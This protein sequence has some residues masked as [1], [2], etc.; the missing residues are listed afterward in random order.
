MMVK[1]LGRLDGLQSYILRLEPRWDKSGYITKLIE[2]K[3]IGSH[4]YLLQRIPRFPNPKPQRCWKND[5]ETTT[6][7]RM[8]TRLRTNAMMKRR[9]SR[10]KARFQGGWTLRTC[11][12]P[13]FANRRSCAAKHCHARQL[14]MCTGGF[15]WS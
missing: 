15:E 1:C 3:C 9:P 10:Y 13:S 2:A 14:D 6:T 11:S 4:L 12:F 8:R 5:V 7:S